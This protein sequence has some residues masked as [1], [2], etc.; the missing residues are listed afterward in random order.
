M[1]RGVITIGESNRC[2]RQHRICV[3]DIS[4]LSNNYYRAEKMLFSD[5]QDHRED[6]AF[7][8]LPTDACRGMPL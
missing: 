6:P 2:R 8:L 4:G 1:A 3:F 7:H 5:L